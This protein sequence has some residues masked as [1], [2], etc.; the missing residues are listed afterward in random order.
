MSRARG[1]PGA[2]EADVKSAYRNAAM[3]FH[4][5]RN[6]GLGA[7]AERVAAER[8]R[9]ASEAYVRRALAPRRRARRFLLLAIRLARAKTSVGR[10]AL[11]SVF[12]KKERLLQRRG[13]SVRVPVQ[14][15]GS[16]GRPHAPHRREH[17]RVVRHVS[18]RRC[19]AVPRAATE[20]A[21]GDGS[22]AQ[23]RG[24]IDARVRRARRAV[25]RAG[26]AA[27]LERTNP[28]RARVRRD[29]RYEFHTQWHHRLQTNER[30]DERATRVCSTR[31]FRRR[32]RKRRDVPVRVRRAAARCARG[33]WR[34]K[35][36]TAP[37][38]NARS[39]RPDTRASSKKKREVTKTSMLWRRTVPSGQT[40]DT[41]GGAYRAGCYRIAGDDSAATR[42]A[43]RAATE[44]KTET[45]TET[46]TPHPRRLLPASRALGVTVLC[47]SRHASA[48]SAA[49]GSRRLRR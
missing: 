43:R 29:T 40:A 1:A 5:D 41:P 6:A 18:P 42:P 26:L 47:R 11:G 14:K 12:S 35:T 31:T 13:G 49:R 16:R 23:A 24:P 20:L 3:K 8:F 2:S 48:P 39:P 27:R 33:R 17:T 19:R 38:A 44:T 9:R 25:A 45:P 46:P 21:R 4:P 34:D 10:W 7:D 30:K 36:R 32:V 22:P 15:I 37:P 28:K